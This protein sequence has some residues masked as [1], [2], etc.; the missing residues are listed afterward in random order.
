MVVLVFWKSS[1]LPFIIWHVQA[2]VVNV[3]GSFVSL[4]SEEIGLFFL[5]LFCFLAQADVELEMEWK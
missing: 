5:L 3:C 4:S 1:V 2:D